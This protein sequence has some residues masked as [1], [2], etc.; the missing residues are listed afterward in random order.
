MQNDRLV[1]LITEAKRKEEEPKMPSDYKVKLPILTFR[2][3]VALRPFLTPKG[4]VQ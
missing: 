3:F 2:K 1:R 4:T